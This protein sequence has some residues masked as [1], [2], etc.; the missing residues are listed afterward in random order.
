VCLKNVGEYHYID[1]TM[2]TPVIPDQKGTTSTGNLDIKNEPTP[3]GRLG[4]TTNT[5]ASREL[6]G[7]T[8]PSQAPTNLAV[9]AK[10]PTRSTTEETSA[11]SDRQEEQDYTNAMRDSILD[12]TTVTPNNDTSTGGKKRDQGNGGPKRRGWK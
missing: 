8:T 7:S 11:R 2:D 1:L 3:G 10:D 4:N 6:F 5:T 12:T 9:A